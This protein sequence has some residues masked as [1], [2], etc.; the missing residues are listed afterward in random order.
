L[1]TQLLIAMLNDGKEATPAAFEKH[2]AKLADFWRLPIC[3]GMEKT[4]AYTRKR[5]MEKRIQFIVPGSQMY[6]PCLGVDLREHFASQKE[7]AAYLSP[8]AQMLLFYV[9]EQK[10]FS[11][12]AVDAVKPLGLPHGSISRAFGELCSH[13]L[14]DRVGIRC[15]AEYRF[16]ADLS[17]IWEKAFPLLRSPRLKTYWVSNLPA[18]INTF[19]SGVDAIAEYTELATGS[20]SIARAVDAATCKRILTYPGVEVFPYLEPE[21]VALE[22]W[23]YNPGVLARNGVVDPRSLYLCFAD[24]KDQ[25]TQIELERMKTQW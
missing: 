4:T 25:R 19:I 3:I 10:R 6:L 12:K 15:N 14:C 9:F 16:E 21:A 23:R 2:L 22:A 5:L 13:G 18:G 17:A 7:K 8:S 11:I 20:G 24:D 1:N